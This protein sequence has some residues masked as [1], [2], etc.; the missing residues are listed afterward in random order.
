MGGALLAFGLATAP[1]LAAS[2]ASADTGSQWALSYLKYPQVSALST[3]EGVTVGLIDSGVSPI[4]D[5]SGQL[6][7]GADFSGASATTSIGDGETDTDSEGHGNGMAS[8][9]AGQGQPVQGLAPHA[10]ILTVRDM[11]STGA[12]GGQDALASSIQYA[13]SRHV[14]VINISEAWLAAPSAASAVAAAVNAGI[15]VVASAGNYSTTVADDPAPAPAVYPGVVDVAAIDQSGAVASFSDYGPQVALAAPGVGVLNDQAYANDTAN[16]SGTSPA[17]A[18]VSATA[19]LIFAEHPAW[20]AG[21]VI[22]VMLGTADPGT[23]QT[24]GQ[25]DDHYGYGIVDPLKALQAAAP[26]QTTNPLLTAAT[27]A[28]TTAAP[29]ASDAASSAAAAPASSSSGSS[30]LLILLGVL[31]VLVV[32]VVAV[33]L[34]R[35]GKSGPGGPPSGPGTGGSHPQ[36]RQQSQH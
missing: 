36:A 17:A 12:P 6:L 2:P 8:I 1:V 28:P 9:I 11:L 27:G 21:Q 20:T 5:I 18:Y 31:V 10:K 30:T 4:A 26:A 34:S 19:A 33:V 15:V 14:Q 22:R 16:A 23:G 29:A 7:P 25:H 32:L 13:I 35:R 24:A 3:G